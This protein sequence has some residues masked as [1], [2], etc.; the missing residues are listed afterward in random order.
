[1]DEFFFSYP[2][3]DNIASSS[4]ILRN[5]TLYRTQKS[6]VIVSVLSEITKY[7]QSFSIYQLGKGSTTVMLLVSGLVPRLLLSLV[8]KLVL[9]LVL[10]LV[11]E[12]VLEQVIEWSGY[13]N[14]FEI[15]KKRH[16][17]IKKSFC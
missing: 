5:L 17:F 9:E 15:L 3:E 16:K 1:M 10:E 11:P 6:T 8:L 7:D 12:L 4:E 2:L 14:K 13:K